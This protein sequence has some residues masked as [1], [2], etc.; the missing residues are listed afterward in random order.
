MFGFVAVSSRLIQGERPH[1]GEFFNGFNFILT[2]LLLGVV[3]QIF[4]FLG[5]LLLVVPGVYLAVGF[6]LAPWF[7]LDRKAGFWE[8]MQLA[9]AGCDRTGSNSLD[10]SC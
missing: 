10:F 8:A 4:I 6:F 5:L 9:G 2:L 3:S 7:V 1:F